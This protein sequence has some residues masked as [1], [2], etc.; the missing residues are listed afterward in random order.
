[1]PLRSFLFLL[2]GTLILSLRVVAQQQNLDESKV[3]PYTLPDPLTFANGSPV[4]NAADWQK[5]RA[6]ILEMAEREMYGRSPARPNA[7]TFQVFDTDPRAL[8]GKA[9][10]KQIRILF[11]GKSTDPYMDLLLYIPNGATKPVPTILGLNFWGNHAINADPAIRLTTNWMESGRNVYI[12]LTCTKNHQATDA[13]R[14]QNANQW[15][16]ETM[17]ARGY[18]VATFYRGDICLDSYDEFKN[19][20]FTLYP[21]L[22]NRSDNFSTIAAWAWGFSRAMDYLVTDKAI[23][24]KRVAIF[25]WS[26][27]GKAAL[28]AG[29]KDT[30]FALLISNESGAGGVALSKRKYGEDVERLN[31]V[32][33]HWFCQNFRKYS[34]KEELLPFDQH[35]VVALLAPRPIYISSAEDDK[36]ADPL[37]EFLAGKAADP[38]Y[39]FLGTEGLPATTFPTLHQP[40]MGQI[41]YHIRSGGHEVTD[42]DWA[43]YLTFMDKH[44]K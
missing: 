13:C 23:D 31:R 22:Q 20:V 40:S 38:V 2:Y 41:G 30:R 11:T 17:L 26:R 14:G 28:W 32:F 8:G 12:D 37:G 15:P 10:R 33:P 21:E 9:T 29:A 3:P 18:A 16:L 1:M 4:K 5:R 36:G 39:R 27:L 34:N 24:A 42:Y 35:M 44:L 43:N 19:G 6:E 25:G 7:M